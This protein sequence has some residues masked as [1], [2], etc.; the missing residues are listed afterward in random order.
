MSE[1]SRPEVPSITDLASDL[2]RLMTDGLNKARPE[3]FDRLLSLRAVKA[4]A[5]IPADPDSQL[6]AL[7]KRISELTKGTRDERLRRLAPYA[8]GNRGGERLGIGKRLKAAQDAGIGVTAEA[9]R[10]GYLDDLTDNFARRLHFLEERFRKNKWDER[11]IDESMHDETLRRHDFYV[12]M[13]FWRNGAALEIKAALEELRAADTHK[14]QD[15]TEAA[16]WRWSKYLRVAKNYDEE[17]LGEWAFRMDAPAGTLSEAIRAQWDTEAL[18]PIDQRDRSWL[19]IEVHATL[20]NEL[21][22]FIV[23]LRRSN[24]GRQVMAAWS[25]WIRGCNCTL[26]H[27][28]RKCSVHRFLRASSTF[29]ALMSE[30]VSADH[31]IDRAAHFQTLPDVVEPPPG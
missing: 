8:F 13:A 19:R 10:K 21:D 12:A 17:F 20:E 16:L 24:R 6:A 14:A 4:V 3:D 29:F 26:S 23:G 1:P 30:E 15:F 7:R 22:P 18:P 11:P 31:C 2:R 25:E 9:L 5:L 28:G 27:P